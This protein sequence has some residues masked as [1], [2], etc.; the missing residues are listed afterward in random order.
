MNV[1][2]TPAHRTEEIEPGKT[3]LDRVEE[4]FGLE[5]CRSA[6]NRR[7]SNRLR[8]KTGCRKER[9]DCRYGGEMKRR[10][11]LNFA[12]WFLRNRYMMSAP[13]SRHYC[14]FQ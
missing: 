7:V 13:F 4:R 5:V 14:R 1:Q 2:A 12:E 6:S 9:G 11:V 3:M 10:N 8:R